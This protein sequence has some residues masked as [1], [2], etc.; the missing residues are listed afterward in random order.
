MSNCKYCGREI[1]TSSL[2]C[3][4]C[5]RKLNKVGF[6]LQTLEA[7]KQTVK[8]VYNHIEKKLLNNGVC[9]NE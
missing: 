4:S 8:N 1:A 2:T 6:L 7:D 5:E 9:K 3:K